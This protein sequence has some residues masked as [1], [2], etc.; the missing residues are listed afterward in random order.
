MDLY[1]Y[2][3][4]LDI[5]GTSVHIEYSWLVI[6]RESIVE[7]IANQARFTYR[8]VTYEHYFDFLIADN[9]R[10]DWSWSRRRFWLFLFF[11]I[12]WWIIR[13]YQWLWLWPG[14]RRIS[15]LEHV[16][17]VSFIILYGLPLDIFFDSGAV[18]HLIIAEECLEESVDCLLSLLDEARFFVSKHLF[19]REG[20]EVHLSKLLFHV[21][22]PLQHRRISVLNHEGAGVSLLRLDFD[23]VDCV[24][25]LMS[26]SA[27]YLS[28]KFDVGISWPSF[29]HLLK[30]FN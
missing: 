27:N 26:F 9:F 5:F 19:L 30:L 12:R 4:F 28:R 25:L 8:G 16:S 3:L 29:D 14:R 18:A 21:A 17:C 15:F 11:F 20:R 24:T 6:L 13:D 23:A 7:V 10:L 2:L 1:L 22:S